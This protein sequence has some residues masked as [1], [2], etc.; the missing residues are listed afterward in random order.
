LVVDNHR[1]AGPRADVP[2]SRV[3]PINVIGRWIAPPAGDRFIDQFQRPTSL[4]KKILPLSVKPPTIE[5]AVKAGGFLGGRPEDII[6]QLKAVE[7]RYPGLDRR[8]QGAA[9]I[10][11]GDGM[12]TPR[13]IELARTANLD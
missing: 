2:C 10:T 4:R 8:H 7:K 1:L 6:E 9:I 3:S 12:A 5:D 13:V 11:K